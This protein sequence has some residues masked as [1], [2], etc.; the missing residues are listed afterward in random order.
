MNLPE[1]VMAV[2]A[3]ICIHAALTHGLVGFWRRRRD[4]VR[5]AFAAAALAA[6]VG[7]LAVLG[8]YSAH[9]VATH[10][11]VMKWAFFPAGVAFTV[12]TVWLVAYYTDVRPRRLLLA[13][14]AALGAVVAIDLVLPLGILHDNA[15]EV[16]MASAGG[17]Q[18]MVM[19]DPS[20]HPLNSIAEVLTL[21]A[22]VFLGY[23]A[24]RVYRRG[25]HTK[26]EYVGLLVALLALTTVVDTLTDHGL[27]TTLY[28]T[29]LGF[30][31]VVVAV[32]V[33][34][35]RESSQDERQLRTARAQLETLLDARVGDLNRALDLLAAETRE[36]AAAQASLERRV[37]E[38]DS[39]QHLAQTLEGR[40]DPGRSLEDACLAIGKLYDAES[41]HVHLLRD[42]AE[43]P[44]DEAAVFA[45]SFCA[46]ADGAICAP[47][48][49]PAGRRAETVMRQALLLREVA[50]S[51]GSEGA[52]AMPA[53]DKAPV[54]APVLAVPLLATSGPMG[55]LVVTRREGGPAFSDDER[56][57]ATLAADRVAAAVEIDQLHRQEMRAAA[58]EERQRLARDLHDAV[59][60]TVYAA[61]LIADAVP[62]MWE[63]D[64]DE[65]RRNL[66]RVRDLTRAALAEMRTL[67]FE[68]RPASLDSATLD[69][70]IQHLA[71]SL[72][73][74][75]EM[76][77]DVSVP[78][79]VELPNEV[80]LA[81][82]RVTQESLS[83]IAR[84]ARASR[85]RVVMAGGSEGVTLTVTDDG[86]G[87]EPCEIPADHM[88]LRIMRE[89]LDR[90]DALLSVDSAPGG[91]T[92][93]RATWR[94]PDS[95][96]AL[97]E[98][99]GA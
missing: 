79:G 55:V 57:L 25:E 68:L 42:D 8:M 78:S 15:G 54:T 45:A 18:I 69:T 52:G 4:R 41:V 39:L 94:P 93:I 89:R 33:A 62:S 27:L 20:P 51:T 12:A 5:L 88:G 3:G 40:G 13:L 66:V 92:T 61:T 16:R 84:H 95:D 87:F 59:T 99:T 90:V 53:D 63:R 74:H 85:V 60:Q 26:G 29:Q 43:P 31:A 35:R 56:H 64:P 9:S 10:I 81:L 47:A 75:G 28:L 38:L 48:E 70:L 22:F 24:Y 77:V 86:K 82:Y 67:L 17:G 14:T 44:A 6:A 83:N 11:A 34:L 91:G 80:K 71:D 72:A 30:V 23:A 19:V 49:E 2:A 7:A 36:R 65:G 32:S 21:A 97:R 50:V 58:L 37:A 46:R 76:V 73:G 98:R 96:G 1:A